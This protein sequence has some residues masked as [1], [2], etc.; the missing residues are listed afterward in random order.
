MKSLSSLPE[1]VI[2]LIL[3]SCDSFHQI[4]CLILASKRMNSAWIR[5][6]RAILWQVGQVAI[7]GF[8]DALIAV[9]AT[10]IATDALLRGEL[11]PDPFPVSELSGDVWKPSLEE[12]KQVQ[13]LQYVANYLEQEI[14]SHD[15]FI[16]MPDSFDTDR[17]EW[18]RLRWKVWHEECHRAI[19]RHLA[20]GAILYRG[21][22]EPIV[23]DGRPA[24]F[25]AALIEIMES[26]EELEYATEG[27]FSASD[28]AYLSE[29]PLYSIR[30]YHMS[31]KVFRALEDL[32]VAES[33]KRELFQPAGVFS[34]RH[35]E[36][37][38]SLF[39]SFRR[40]TD[41][42]NPQ[43]L[44][45][46]HVENLFHQILHF[47]FM[48]EQCPQQFILDARGTHDNKPEKASEKEQST[49][50]IFFE[51]FVPTKIT[52]R[53]KAEVSG[54]LALP[55]LESKTL[56]DSNYFGFQYMDTLLTKVWQ[57]GG[58]PNC[59]GRD[60]RPPRPQFYF[61]EYM[62]RKYFGLRFAN[63]D[64]AKSLEQSP[65]DAFTQYGG[66]FSN[67]P[68]HVFFDGEGLFQSSDDPLPPLY[69]KDAFE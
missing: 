51:A 26:G 8:S 44:D 18:A 66:V 57:V 34:S 19:Y 47:M 27:W 67:V 14:R 1:E 68:S 52:I 41:I 59:Y 60:D 35:P 46:H 29:I 6:E 64:T 36:R 15:L 55:G 40:Y 69:Y 43:S 5:Y 23:S 17:H 28:R 24:D 30:D 63:E 21:Y 49:L 48:V 2:A 38:R 31:E 10:K 39:Q 53:D 42:R 54:A 20:A 25:L 11:P 50:A 9:R 12:L 62:L 22:H 58:I 56:K 33:G 7:T 13:T 16:A 61:A 37:V 4:R 65:W 3:Q 32:F 45:G